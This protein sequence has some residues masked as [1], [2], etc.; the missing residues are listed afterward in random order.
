MDTIS[1][2][3]AFLACAWLTVGAFASLILIRIAWW[4]ETAFERKEISRFKMFHARDELVGLVASG[5]MSEEDHAWIWTYG[6][7]TT[8]LRM[9]QK[10][11]LLGVVVRYAAYLAKA[12]R[13][14]K[15]RQRAAERHAQLERAASLNPDFARVQN[16]TQEAFVMMVVARTTLMNRVLLK[17]FMFACSIVVAFGEGLSV[18]RSLRR[19]NVSDIA[20]FACRS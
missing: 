7:V 10:L 8:L 9:H 15:E 12:R 4:R 13:D 16:L 6:S 18:Y 14:P 5:S 2:D 20:G 11:H 19:P 1:P 17:M 3:T